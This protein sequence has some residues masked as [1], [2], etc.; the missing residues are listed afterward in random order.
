MS[1]PSECWCCCSS[2][3]SDS[4]WPQP[5]RLPCPRGCWSVLPGPPPGDLPGSGIE[6]VSPALWAN[7]LPL[8]P[9]LQNS[10]W[11]IALALS[12]KLWLFRTCYSLTTCSKNVTANSVNRRQERPVG[13][14]IISQLPGTNRWT[15]N[16]STM[17]L[18]VQVCLNWEHFSWKYGVIGLLT[19][20]FYPIFTLS[21]S[22]VLLLRF[23]QEKGNPAVESQSCLPVNPQAGGDPALEK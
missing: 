1:K 8:N 11:H 4:L 3:E 15:L 22:P 10:A 21:P 23:L 7:S 12:C 6:P 2:V 19:F 13:H 5:T 14:T 18:P 16:S 20:D 17:S 9:S